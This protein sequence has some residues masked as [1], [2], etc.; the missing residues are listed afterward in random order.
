MPFRA[1]Y[2][3]HFGYG[4]VE[5]RSEWSVP[6]G[7]LPVVPTDGI[8]LYEEH[9]LG[10]L[11]E[12]KQA[13]AMAGQCDFDRP[14]GEWRRMLV[15]GEAGFTVVDRP[16][17][18]G[19]ARGWATFVTETDAAGMKSARVTDW[20]VRGH[21]DFVRMLAFFGTLKDQYG[22]L[23]LVCPADWQVSRILRETQVPHRPVVHA[24]ASWRT[25]TRMQVRVL[26]HKRL[27]EGVRWPDTVRG[28]AEVC[29][30]ECEGD[31]SRFTV[32]VEGG[33]A[34]VRPGGAGRGFVTK[35]IHWAAV[36]LG[37]LPAGEALRLGL[38]E[39]EAA[40]AALMAG[41]E[42]GPRPYSL[43]YF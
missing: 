36:A 11:V 41:L 32:E 43:E 14:E 10:A 1:S 12:L 20:G 21:A 4:V 38:A 42:A 19:Q 7:L 2:Y 37:D 15:R 31:E 5:R 26:D 29:V 34:T 33:R 40:A 24:T 35:D 6:V 18:H 28:K 22:W 13:V 8:K 30:Q 17:G 9:D 25:H 23:H 39:G 3:E 16:E 27:L